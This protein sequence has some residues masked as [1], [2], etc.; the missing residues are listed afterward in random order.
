MRKPRKTASWAR[1]AWLALALGVVAT[2]VQGAAWWAEAGSVERL[3]QPA[4]HRLD[5][6]AAALQGQLARYDYLPR[7][8]PLDPGITGLLER[9]DDAAL[10]DRANRHLEDLNRLAGSTVIYLLDVEGRVVASSNWGSV[11]SF[12]GMDL[13]YRPYFQDAIRAGRGRF[14]GIGTTS[15]EPGYYFA[16]AIAVEGRPLGVA[17][18]KV[19]LGVI[20]RT[21]APGT[22]KAFV[23]DGNGVVILASEP[24]WKFR[25]TGDLAPDVL[26][27]L[28]ATRQ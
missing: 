9:S 24:A 2:S 5:V 20:E 22:E 11:D 27:R 4:I 23:T 28:N 18:V 21:W 16:Q 3:R 25:S 12:V 7:I 8:L 17:A 13:A 6:Y 14:Y 10:K 15:G 1:W 19:S 26:Q